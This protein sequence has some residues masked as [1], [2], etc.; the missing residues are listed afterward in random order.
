MEAGSLRVGERILAKGSMLAQSSGRAR[1]HA[2]RIIVTTKY[3]PFGAYKNVEGYEYMRVARARLVVEAALNEIPYDE[4]VHALKHNQ[5]LSAT[6]RYI[7]TDF[8]VHHDDENTLNDDLSNL[9]VLS[10]AEHARLHDQRANFRFDAIRELTIRKIESVEDEM[11]YDVQMESPANNFCANGLLVHNCGKTFAVKAWQQ[12]EKGLMLCATTGIAA[13]NLGGTTIN[14]ALGYFDSKSLQESYTNG[15][16][17]ARLGRLWKAGVRRLVVDEV[18]ML[19]GD[20]LTFLVKGVEEVNGRGYVLG[21]WDEED[22]TEPPAMG[23]T[24]VGDFAQL[25]PVK[26]PFAWES[27]EWPRFAEHT[28]TLSEIRRQTDADFVQA[29]RQARVGNGAAVLEALRGQLHD[30]TDDQFEG[31]TLFA[32][33]DAVDRYNWIRLSR[34][35]GQDL[36]FES[37]RE[38]E[39]RS[40]WGNPKKEPS[41]WGIPIRLHTKVGAL[42]MILAN[43]REEGPPPQPFIYVN[44]DLG[45]VTGGDACHAVVRLQRTGQEVDVTYTRREVLQPIDSARRKELRDQGQQGRITENGKFEITGWIEYLPLRTAYASTVHKSQGLSLDRLQVNIRDA[46]FKTGGMLYVA[47][48]RCRT[49]EGLRIVGS[50][51]ALIER[52]AAD[53]RL[54]AWL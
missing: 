15:F 26:E 2:P 42:V 9:V 28:V 30:Q 6:F 21:K 22:E 17:T 16:L 44:G 33:N 8:E 52:C 1:T 36:Y 49:R 3:H 18:S 20:Q 32:K 45:E 29:L 37:R 34:V 31:P 14:A 24:L 53:P 25:P 43:E 4:F 12:Q 35:Q 41:T 50:E 5:G 48:S 40:E 19:S 46:F 27:P 23:L 7:P 13:I 54:K 47:L 39:Q 51:A 11:T 38:G 10:K